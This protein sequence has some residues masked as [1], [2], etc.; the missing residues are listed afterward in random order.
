MV[1]VHFWLSE[2]CLLQC[3]KDERIPGKDAMKAKERVRRVGGKVFLAGGEVGGYIELRP[4]P[5]FDGLPGS[6]PSVQLAGDITADFNAQP[7]AAVVIDS[8]HTA[9]CVAQCEGITDHRVPVHVK[10]APTFAP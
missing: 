8:I 6:A 4:Q 7:T 10:I 1:R 5:V 9:I 2:S 3:L